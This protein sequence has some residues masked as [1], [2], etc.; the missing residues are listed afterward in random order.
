[1]DQA[2]ELGVVHVVFTGGEPLLREDIVELVAYAHKVGLISRLSTNGILLTRDM[3]ARLKR[4]GLTQCGVS[5]DDPDPGTHD[6][7]RGVPGT[8]VKAIEGIRH[9]HEFNLNCRILTYA[10]HRTVT[11][12]LREIIEIGRRL[13]VMSVYIRFPVAS[14][15]WDN[16]YHEI[17]SEEERARTREL[18]DM[19][20][21]CCEQ[22]T[23]E[24]MCC[25]CN[26]SVFHVTP[27]GEVTPCGYVPYVL[28]SLR[29]EPLSDIWERH[30]SRLRLKWRDDCPMND[31][32]AREALREHVGSV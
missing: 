7:L 17:L 27:S 9:L 12:G 6:R 31:I 24:T 19:S 20:F 2:K 16:A 1:M 14:G 32:A 15:R 18:Q 29:D 23:P 8:F 21:V 26:K 3:V 11:K 13:K 4:A 22:P 5:I 30:V 10:S 28:G 25:M